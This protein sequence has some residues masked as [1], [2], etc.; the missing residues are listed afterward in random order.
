VWKEAAANTGG[1]R[2]LLAGIE[3]RHSGDTEQDNRR[4]TNQPD[5]NKMEEHI[6]P[7]SRSLSS[8]GHYRVRTWVSGIAAE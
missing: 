1:C 4:G 8:I 6:H 5:E 2:R 7:E 3:E